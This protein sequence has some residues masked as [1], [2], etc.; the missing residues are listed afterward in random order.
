MENVSSAQTL[1][2]IDTD[3]D[4]VVTKALRRRV[5]DT[6]R[7]HGGQRDVEITILLCWSD[8]REG[9]FGSR[10]LGGYHQL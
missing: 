10:W 7:P 1:I 4:F 3:L 8:D 6:K 9:A 5:G 2:N